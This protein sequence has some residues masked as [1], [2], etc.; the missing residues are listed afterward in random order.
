MLYVDLASRGQ[1]MRLPAAFFCYPATRL[2]GACPHGANGLVL[3]P[4]LVT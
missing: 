4:T 2:A 1:D 3:S